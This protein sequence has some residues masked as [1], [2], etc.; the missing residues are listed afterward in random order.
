MVVVD[1]H[2]SRYHYGMTARRKRS[3]IWKMSVEQFAL[4]IEQSTTYADVLR[5]FGLE[6]KGGN[7]AT[8]KRRI[9]EDGID[10]GHIASGAA[11]RQRG[12]ASSP[13]LESVLV[14]GSSYSRRSLK[15]RVIG[16]GLLKEECSECGLGPEWNGKKLVLVLDH[17]NGVS[18]DNRLKNLRLLCPNCNSQQPT[19]AARNR[20]KVIHR[21]DCG[22][23][24]SKHYKQCK[25]CYAVSRKTVIK[26]PSDE[27][28][29]AMVRATNKNQVAKRLGVSFNAVKKRIQRTKLCSPK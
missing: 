12:F 24:R 6:P 17:I 8:L 11:R 18:N 7:T 26:W 19:F 9:V 16:V 23:R 15:R 22:R 5:A 3:P 10:A 25:Q 27:D 13:S 20:P 28:L 21:C 1:F 29:L 4:L 14:E 2:V